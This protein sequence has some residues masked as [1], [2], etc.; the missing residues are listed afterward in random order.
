MDSDLAS[1]V[2]MAPP[3]SYRWGF[4]TVVSVAYVLLLSSGVLTTFGIWQIAISLDGLHHDFNNN[5]DEII[6]GMAL[7]YKLMTRLCEIY[8]CG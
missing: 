4:I 3:G 6:K 8:Q 5:K 1:Y 2:D 7:F